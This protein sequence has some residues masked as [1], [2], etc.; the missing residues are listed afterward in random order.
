MMVTVL[1]AI[2][3]HDG[4]LIASYGVAL[5]VIGAALLKLSKTFKEA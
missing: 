2:A 3:S 1:G 4:L 5:L